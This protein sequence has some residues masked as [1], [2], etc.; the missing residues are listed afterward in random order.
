MAGLSKL[1]TY[2][3]FWRMLWRLFVLLRPFPAIFLVVLS[4]AE[5]V[6]VAK[7]AG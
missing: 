2:R 5:A 6:V 4:V 7:G 3:G 1:R